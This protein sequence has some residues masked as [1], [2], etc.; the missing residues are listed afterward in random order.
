MLEN[1]ETNSLGIYKGIQH[2]LCY[3]IKVIKKDY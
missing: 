3:A 1:N 2:K